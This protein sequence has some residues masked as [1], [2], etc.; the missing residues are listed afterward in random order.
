MALFPFVSNFEGDFLLQLV[1][2]DTENT[3]DEI[4]AAAAGHSVGKRVFP[5]NDKV[6]RVRIQGK[7]EPLAR[8]V[9]VEGAKLAPMTPLEFYYEG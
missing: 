6:I 2:A 8:D 1:A 4:A 7:K 5:Q 9:T 3:M